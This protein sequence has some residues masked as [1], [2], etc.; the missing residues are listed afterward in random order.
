MSLGAVSV[1]G[2]TSTLKLETPYAGRGFFY[3]R[4][5]AERWLTKFRAH[6]FYR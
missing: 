1:A 6:N 4:S 3:L 5:W 2:V